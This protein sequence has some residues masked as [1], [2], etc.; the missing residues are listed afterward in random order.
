MTETRLP[1]ANRFPESSP[2]R[3]RPTFPPPAWS[4][5]VAGNKV[6][7]TVLRPVKELNVL[8]N[9]IYA[10]ESPLFLVAGESRTLQLTY[11]GVT[12]CATPSVVAYKN[13]ADVSS[14]VMPA[15]SHTAST[16]TV[17]LKPLTAL[18]AGETY[19]LAVTATCDGD[20]RVVKVVV[21]VL[22]PKTP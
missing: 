16:N 2:E 22:D 21:H 7:I 8:T 13:G 1:I 20:T 15:G 18:T 10:H 6:Q 5:T 17:T 9:T 3:W 4:L 14:T 11:Q 19:V 12:T